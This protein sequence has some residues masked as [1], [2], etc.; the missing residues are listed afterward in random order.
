MLNTFTT[1]H[2]FFLSKINETLP[3]AALQMEEKEMDTKTGILMV[4]TA[5]TNMTYSK[6]EQ[7]AER[8]YA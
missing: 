4:T 1:C 3:K 5:F 8:E 2:S 6:T 7:H